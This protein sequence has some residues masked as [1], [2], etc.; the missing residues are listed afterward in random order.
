M[1]RKMVR[2]IQKLMGN[3]TSMTVAMKELNAYMNSA[4]FKRFARLASE[5][6]ATNS[7]AGIHRTWK[8]AAKASGRGKDIYKAISKELTGTATGR[9]VQDIV[10]RNSLLIKTVPHNV[11][12]D[13]SKTANEMTRRGL[14][15]E[16]ISAEIQEKCV[17]LAKHEVNRIARTE[18]AKATTALLQARCQDVGVDWYIWGSCKDERVRDSHKF[19]E[20]IVCRWSDPPNP[21]ALSGKGQI[22]N[23]YHPGGV[24]NCRCVALPITDVRLMSFPCRVHVSGKLVTIRTEAEFR[25]KFLGGGE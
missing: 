10:Y 2:E 4:D 19:M 6:M 7:A 20:G 3:A 14:R 16:D 18:S 21:E 25:K 12:E 15:W 22:R 8:E 11:A 9:A 24:Y 13:L 17:G 23:S 1:L 5:R